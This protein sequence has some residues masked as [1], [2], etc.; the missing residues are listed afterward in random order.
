M[1]GRH[2]DHIPQPLIDNNQPVS[3]V[4]MYSN[5][6]HNNPLFGASSTI[7]I[8]QVGLP[9]GGLPFQLEELSMNQME[10]Q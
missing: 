9:Q 5:S 2:D 10:Y 3:T 4:D 7:P 1:Q 8:G 6:G